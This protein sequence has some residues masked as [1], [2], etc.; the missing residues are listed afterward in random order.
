MNYRPHKWFN[1]KNVF[2]KPVCS[3]CGLMRL[4]NK[5]THWCVKQG[6]Y[7]DEHPHYNKIFKK[8]TKDKN[9]WH[10]KKHTI[11]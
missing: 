9:I 8:L 1:P 7:Y 2:Y 3:G 11:G 10:T 4:N 5:I 6:C